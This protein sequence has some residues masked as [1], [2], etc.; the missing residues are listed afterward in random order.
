MKR[1]ALV[2]SKADAR[3]LE[4]PDPKI[5]NAFGHAGPREATTHAFS[6]LLANPSQPLKG[7]QFHHE[8]GANSGG[9][10]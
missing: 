6:R 1:R 3:Q 7:N 10:A 9:T 2:R 5:P 4:G 8:K